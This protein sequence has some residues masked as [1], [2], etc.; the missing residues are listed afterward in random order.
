MIKKFILI[1]LLLWTSAFAADTGYV[2]PGTGD[3]QIYAGSSVDWN[4]N[5]LILSSNDQWAYT[6]ATPSSERYTNYLVARN[7]GLSIPASAVINGIIVKIERHKLYSFTTTT[8]DKRVSLRLADGSI[9]SENK[10]SATEYPGSSDGIATYGA[11]NDTWGLTLTGADVNDADFGVALSSTVKACFLKG[12][13]ISTPIGDKN[14]E[15]LKEGEDIISFNEDKTLTTSK[16]IALLPQNVIHT[17]YISVGNFNCRVSDTHPFLVPNYSTDPDYE[18]IWKPA[19]LLVKGDTIYVNENN[20]IVPKTIDYI[21]RNEGRYD[22]Y[23]L[24]VTEP[25]TFIANGFAVHNKTM[26]NAYVDNMQIQV[27]YTTPYSG[28]VTITEE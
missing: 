4:S 14:I 11:N 15:D 9:G 27:Y 7:F 3:S 1:F 23:D 17:N 8:Y 12:T 28:S 2:N 22:V 13:K 21:S 18:M 10:A 26:N 16:V 25:N 19:A 24:A 6:A 20:S 5:Y